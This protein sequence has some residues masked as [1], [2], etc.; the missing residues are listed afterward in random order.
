M[1]E[2]SIGLTGLFRWM[3]KGKLREE[4]SVP[5]ATQLLN[6]PVELETQVS[7]IYSFDTCWL[8][9]CNKQLLTSAELIA[10]S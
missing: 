4:S 9:V 8:P 5:K 2:Q 10:H 1:N 3:T 6:S 7:F